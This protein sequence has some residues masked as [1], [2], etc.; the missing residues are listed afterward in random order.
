MAF[1]PSRSKRHTTDSGDVKLNL[2]S[3]MDM[4]TI[5]LLFLLKVY[6]TGGQMVQPS[7]Y[8]TL[9]KSTVEKVPEVALDLSISKEW[10][11][12]NDKPVVKIS[13]LLSSNNIVIP[14]LQQQLLMYANEA[15]K[16]QERYGKPFSGMVSIQ[17][18]KSIPYKV[19]V[20]VMATCGKSKYPNMRLYVYQKSS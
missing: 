6:S 10:V 8:L 12:L 15:E 5:I 9:P 4:F 14:K 3:M 20:K 7:D 13:D 11:V 19:L 16:M 17:G 1:I 18:D 2:N